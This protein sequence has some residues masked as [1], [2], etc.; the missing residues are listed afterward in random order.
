MRPTLLLFSSLLLAACGTP[1]IRPVADATKVVLKD[2]RTGNTLGVFNEAYIGKSDYYSET[3]V[4]AAFKVIPDE[5]M[6][7]LLEQLEDFD[8]F[9]QAEPSLQRT[10]GARTT[11]MVTRG[12]QSWN[13]AWTPRDSEAIIQTAQECN[14][15]FFAIYNA[16]FSYQVIENSE[17]NNIFEKEENRLLQQ[18]RRRR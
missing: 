15:A 1:Q 7:A 10:P 13:L 6:G 5:H 11:L 3:R 12:D 2:H 9:A 8:Y 17:G 16:T 18:N 14:A 4:S